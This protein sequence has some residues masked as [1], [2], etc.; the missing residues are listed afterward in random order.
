MSSENG[1]PNVPYEGVC[2]CLPGSAGSYCQFTD[3]EVCNC[4]G[5]VKDNGLCDCFEGFEGLHCDQK[6]MT[7][8]HLTTKRSDTTTKQSAITTKQSDTTTK[9][10]AI[11]TKRSD[12]ITKRSSVTTKR[13]AITTKQSST[14][15][16]ESNYHGSIH[17]KYMTTII[18]LIIVIIFIL[19]GILIFCL[20][21]EKVEITKEVKG[22]NIINNELYES[23]D[24]TSNV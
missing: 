10:S 18:I 23:V 2:N 4:E 11:T 7:T 14:K 17:K 19:I 16:T 8:E 13:S 5:K 21:N 12:T 20:K 9:Q 6:V 24:T 1:Y 3:E 15:P 22:H